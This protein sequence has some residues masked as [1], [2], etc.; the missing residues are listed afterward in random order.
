MFG[1]YP[2][3]PQ[4]YQLPYQQQNRPQGYGQQQMDNMGVMDP[5][6]LNARYVTCREEAT[7]AQIQPDGKVNLFVHAA[8]GRIYTKCFNPN[9]GI[10]E[11]REYGM[12][13]PQEMQYAPIDAL[14]ALGARVEQLEQALSNK[15]GQA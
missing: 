4:G 15:E 6:A 5:G 3:Q 1:G 7:A 12:I 10:A 14:Q 9:T 11:F 2:W 13:Q 8:M